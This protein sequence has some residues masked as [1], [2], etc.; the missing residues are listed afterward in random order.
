MVEAD[1]DASSGDICARLSLCPSRD[2]RIVFRVVFRVVVR[3]LDADTGAPVS[4]SGS[5]SIIKV[6]TNGLQVC[7][8][9]AV[10]NFD[11]R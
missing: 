6:R 9:I 4:V 11:T 5:W 8:V 10:F 2:F 1:P 3:A 7:A